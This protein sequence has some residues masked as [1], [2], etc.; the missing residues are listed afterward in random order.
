MATRYGNKFGDALL[1]VIGT[2]EDNGVP[3]DEI[4]DHL[5]SAIEMLQDA[6]KEQETDETDE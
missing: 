3:C 1:S 4:L 6:K 2:A 5:L